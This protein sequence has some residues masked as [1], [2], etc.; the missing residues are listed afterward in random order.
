MKK[1]HLPQ[2]QPILDWKIHSI[3]ASRDII[4]GEP[5]HP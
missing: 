5:A 4:H 2:I 3:A 1:S